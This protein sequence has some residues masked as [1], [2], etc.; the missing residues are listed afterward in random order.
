MFE[1]LL[2]QSKYLL[3]KHNF[4]R[5]RHIETPILDSKEGAGWVYEPLCDIGELAVFMR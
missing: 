5:V 1:R 2:G 4:G 3:N